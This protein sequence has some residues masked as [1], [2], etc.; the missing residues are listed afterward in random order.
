[1]PKQEKTNVT[2]LEDG[3]SL[4]FLDLGHPQG[5]PI[6]Y[7]HGGLSC[8]LDILSLD[9]SAYNQGL[10]IIAPDRPGIRASERSQGRSLQDVASD[11]QQLLSLLGIEEVD[12]LG[13]SA[14]GVYALYSAALLGDRARNVVTVG[15]PALTNKQMAQMGELP[16]SLTLGSFV[17]LPKVVKNRLFGIIAGDSDQQVLQS[18]GGESFDSWLKGAMR[19]GSGGLIDDFSALSKPWLDDLEDI[20]SK[21]TIFH[22]DK[23]RIVDPAD[24]TIIADNLGRAQVVIIPDRGHLLL[25]HDPTVIY[26][27]LSDDES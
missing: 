25:H 23:D 2:H 26:Q 11:S 14:G 4:S 16:L 1:L 20:T 8:S 9:Q 24:A 17:L 12:L 27:A 7:H 21:T 10:R 18:L 5:R 13:W 22:G 19:Q 6:L 15:T 3:R